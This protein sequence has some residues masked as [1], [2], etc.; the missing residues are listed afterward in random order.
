L[1]RRSAKRC[2]RGIP[3]PCCPTAGFNGVRYAWCGLAGVA[4]QRRAIAALQERWPDARMEETGPLRQSEPGSS[5]D[6]RAASSVG[7]APPASNRASASSPASVRRSGSRPRGESGTAEGLRRPESRA[8][9]PLCAATAMPPPV[10]APE[11]WSCRTQPVPRRGPAAA[12]RLRPRAVV[13]RP[14]ARH[15]P[16]TRRGHV[17]RGAQHRCAVGVGSQFAQGG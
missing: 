11:V 14:D 16:A 3:R 9:T 7:L 6:R 5:P 13:G 8:T 1:R 10:T 17:Q 4:N 2:A 15:Q 12:L